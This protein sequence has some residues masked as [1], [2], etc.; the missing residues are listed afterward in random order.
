MK[1]IQMHQGCSFARN[2]RSASISRSFS[3]CLKNG[4]LST[5]SIALMCVAQ[6]VYANHYAYL[7]DRD[8]KVPPQQLLRSHP[9][10][11]RIGFLN[12]LTHISTAMRLSKWD[13]VSFH[14]ADLARA[15]STQAINPDVMILRMFNPRG[16]IGFN[17]PGC[18]QGIHM[19]FNSSGGLNCGLFD[20]CGALALRA[21]N[22]ALE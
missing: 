14:G 20:I 22:H 5:I 11:P 1:F 16:Y 6:G 8:F 13:M 7:D 4:I 15:A 9:K 21:G 12:S 10:W 3:S 18:Q 2:C 17:Q 19:P